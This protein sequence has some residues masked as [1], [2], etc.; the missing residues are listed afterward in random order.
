MADEKGVETP[1]PPTDKDERGVPWEQRA[2]EYERKFNELRGEVDAL[3]ARPEPVP[4]PKVDQEE[5]VKQEL[6]RLAQNPRGYIQEVLTETDFKKELPKAESW[7]KTQEGYSSSDDS[8]IARVIKEHHINSPS[9]MVRAQTAW[10]LLQSEKLSKELASLRSNQ[11]RESG[12]RSAP[13]NSGRSAQTQT[14]KRS[15]L[16][17]KLRDAERR[18]DNHASAA[19]LDQ[20]E[21][22]RG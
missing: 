12:Q 21:D 15:E 8:E 22:A 20:L 9:P 11:E 13:D 14:P 1:V 10:K 19:L 5:A 16:L 6:V 18:G 3:K 2:K 7:I 4:E 17:A